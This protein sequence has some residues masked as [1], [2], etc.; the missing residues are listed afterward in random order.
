M[1][2]RDIM[3]PLHSWL[4]PE[5]TVLD[6]IEAM[7]HSRRSH[8][9]PLNAI[10]V[11]DND[12]KLVGIVSTT[13][14][15]RLLIPSYMYL[16]DQ[17]ED[18]SSWDPVRADRTERARSLHVRDI[19]TEDVRVINLHDSIMRC[20]DIMLVEQIRRLPVVGTEGK[21]LGVVYLRDVYNNITEILCNTSA[22]V[23]NY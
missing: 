15:L 10:I 20:A 11:L 16:D 4:T 5:M 3:E 19:M 8:G 17:I 14:I 9:L 12:R 21:V 2:V 13:D 7:K 6:A 18:N 23:A 1:K 22:A